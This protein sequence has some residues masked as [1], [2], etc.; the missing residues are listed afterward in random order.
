MKKEK[1]SPIKEILFTYLA[2]NKI[3]Y[4]FNTIINLNQSDL[5]NVSEIVLERILTQDLQLIIGV[6]VIFY[7]DKLIEL[8]KSKYSSVLEYA[9]FYVIGFVVLASIS[10]TYNL[11]MVMIFSAQNVNISEFAG[12]FI[13]FMPIFAL[14]YL[15]VAVA[16]EAKLY[17]KKK[18]TKT[19]EHAA[20][21]NEDKLAMLKILLDDNT[22]TQEEYDN[23]KIKY[24]IPNECE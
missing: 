21:G 2:V 7:L 6:A 24:I 18:E 9:L 15:V 16:L 13:S 10:F 20:C 14:G 4:W 5:G 19:Y 11:I 8:K 23:K 12:E 17:F 1:W 3:M 22:L